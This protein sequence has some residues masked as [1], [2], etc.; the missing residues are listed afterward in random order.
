[1]DGEKIAGRTLQSHPRRGGEDK[2]PS[3]MVAPAREVETLD[4]I[5]FSCKPEDGLMNL[6]A[7][8]GGESVLLLVNSEK[9]FP[10]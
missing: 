7:R 9:F 2:V 3:A 1:M 8:D 10:T 4:Q 5:G 6:G